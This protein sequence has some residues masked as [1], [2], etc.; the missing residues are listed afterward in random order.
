MFMTRRSLFRTGA[1]AATA[2][3]VPAAWSSSPTL[4]ATA[5]PSRPLRILVLGGTRYLGPAFVKAALGRGHHI[6]LFNRGK[7]QP[8]L[9]PGVERLRGNRYPDV[10]GGMEALKPGEWDVAVDLCAY[11]P[12]LVEASATLLESRVKRYVMVSSISVYKDLKQVGITED[13]PVHALAETFEELPDLYENDWPTYGGRKAAGEAIVTRVYGDRATI[14][15]PCS[16]FGG[17][18]NDGTGVYWCA[19][20]RKGGRVLVPGNGSDPT[21][22][23]DVADV[24]DFMVLAAERDL[25]GAYNTIGPAQPLKVKEFIDTAARVVNSRADIVWKGDFPREMY[26]LPMIPPSELVPGFATMSHAKALRAGLKLRPIEDS[27]RENWV[28]HRARRGDAYDF[29]ANG[30]GLSAEAEAALLDA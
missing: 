3:L 1:A 5:P 25:S 15:R 18:N 30:V 19:R 27:M 8:D 24:A 16:I 13:A 17:E 7:T 9:F 2:A 28:D 10:D 6:T 4:S 12:R 23:I 26:G 11:Y 14:I 29:S 21:Q 22:M 20:L